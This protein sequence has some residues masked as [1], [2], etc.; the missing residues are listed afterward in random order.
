ME[1]LQ[2]IRRELT[3]KYNQPVRNL[4]VIEHLFKLW[5]EKR[6]YDEENE[7]YR[8]PAPSTYVK[9]QFKQEGCKT[10]KCFFMC[11]TIFA[12]TCRSDRTS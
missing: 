7:Q 4:Q 11:R 5:F 8:P 1:N 9:I 3:K 2:K 6:G 12:A 10:K